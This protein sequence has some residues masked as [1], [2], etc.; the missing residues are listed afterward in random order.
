VKLLIFPRI[1]QHT[2]CL[3]HLIFYLEKRESS[4]LVLSSTI[5]CQF[6]L[7][8]TTT[9]SGGHMDDMSIKTIDQ[10]PDSSH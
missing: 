5:I 2:G 9:P 7:G 1:E 3:S 8:I 4:N 6:A 10:A